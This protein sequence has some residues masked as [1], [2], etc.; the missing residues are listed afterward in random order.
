M[1]R[2]FPQIAIG[3]KFAAL[4]DF[5]VPFGVL[6]RS[7]D[8]LK[9][10]ERWKKLVLYYIPRTFFIY[11]LFSFIPLVG[12]IIYMLCLVPLSASIQVTSKSGGRDVF[13]ETVLLY[14]VVILIG[15]G[16]VWSFIGHTFMADDIAASIGWAAGSPFQTEL[17]FYTLGTSV[18]AFLA[19]WL[20]GHLITALVV[21]KS[22]FLYGAAFV[23]IEDAI[24]GGNYAIS[25]IGAPLIGDIIY[26][27]L[28]L[29][30]LFKTF[31][32]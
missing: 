22:I 20:R 12:G 27:T 26:P 11:W 9:P 7:S 10:F 23:H 18:A 3:T 17:A 24:V 30:L 19:I 15:F 29:M 4:V 16:G 25:N 31:R 13:A 2:M 28:F 8:D 1:F 5:L 14:L 6:L 21:T 32:V